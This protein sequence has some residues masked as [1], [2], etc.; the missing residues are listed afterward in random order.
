M[1]VLG[2]QPVFWEVPAEL[3]QLSH[4]QWLSFDRNQLTGEIP[5]ELSQLSQLW[6]LHL[7]HNQ[8]K[9]AIQAS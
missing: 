3:G 7:Q 2:S 6:A 5:A 4:L 8:L 1:V 9:E